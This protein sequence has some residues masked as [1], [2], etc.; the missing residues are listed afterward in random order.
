[1]FGAVCY[2]SSLTL[3]QRSQLEQQQKRS[4]AIILGSDYRSY[5]QARSQTNLP[6]LDQLREEACQKWALKAQ[7]SQK[8]S[9]LFTVNTSQLVTRH[10]EKF[11]EPSC[12]TA[13]YYN[14]AVPS[15][16]RFLNRI[17]ENK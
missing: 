2:H 12:K 15:M 7:A 16:I 13:R 17:S 9:H 3:N 1:M 6:E 4:L 10:R 11:R 14:S 8:H 5:D